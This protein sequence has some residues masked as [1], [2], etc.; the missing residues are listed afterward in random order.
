MLT[1]HESAHASTSHAFTHTPP[2]RSVSVLASKKA[3]Q[4][5]IYPMSKMIVTIAVTSLLMLAASADAAT[6]TWDGDTNND[7]FTGTNW[8]PDQVP[9]GADD[10]TISSGTPTATANVDTSN[11]GSVLINGGDVTWSGRFNTIGNLGTGSLLITS[12]SLTVDHN[13]TQSHS[14]N[15]GNNSATGILQ[16]QGGT[17]NAENS[18]DEIKIGR[19]SGSTGTYEISGGTLNAGRVYNGANESGAGTGLFHIIG[20]AAAINLTGSGGTSYSQN[21]ASTLELDINGI[22]AIDAAADVILAGTLDV[23]FLVTP[24]IGQMFTI[25]DYGGTLSG[26]FGTFDNVV[27]SPAG[28]DSITL[29]IDYGSGTNDAVVLTVTDAPA[30]IPAPAAL[31]AGLAMLAML[32]TRRRR[33]V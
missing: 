27:D 26:T 19:V 33:A 25:I 23:E 12:G 13:T 4:M 9:T 1:T 8:N 30:A 21:A 11:G 6:L 15:V 20:D 28:A 3:T 32:A 7:W 17:V 18:N 16:Q 5:E 10:L 24:T 29:S 22:S 31:P 14:F 2:A